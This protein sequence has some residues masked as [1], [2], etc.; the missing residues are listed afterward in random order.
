[1]IVKSKSDHSSSTISRISLS[2]MSV[3]SLKLSESSM[4]TLRGWSVVIPARASIVRVIT[5]F[6]NVS[7]RNRYR[8][9]FGVNNTSSISG[10]VFI[11]CTDGCLYIL[12]LSSGNKIFSVLSLGAPVCFISTKT[13][14]KKIE[15]IELNFAL[16]ACTDGEIYVWEVE[17]ARNSEKIQAFVDL[18]LLFKANVRSAIQ[19]IRSESNGKI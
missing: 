15:D 5:F 9:P 3:I 8:L 7:A 14:Q 18:S 2:V 6:T 19:S 13:I 4:S 16:A 17:T 11:G 12:S 10:V 1:M